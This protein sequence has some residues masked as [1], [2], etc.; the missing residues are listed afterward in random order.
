MTKYQQFTDNIVQ[1][2]HHDDFVIGLAA[3]GSWITNELDDY[4]DIDLVMVTR[5]KIGGDKARMMAY[6]AQFG[7]LLNAFTG[8]HVGEP[9]L[10][11]C[12]YDHPLLHVDIKFV[13]LEEFAH[14][15]ETPVLL[16][17]KAN[18]LQQVLDSTISTYPYPDNQWIEDRFWIWI[19]YTLLKAARGEYFEALDAIGF[20]RNIVIGP[21]LHIRHGNLPRRLRRV[22]MHLPTAAVDDLK[23]TLAQY[24]KASIMD[25]LRQIINMYLTLRSNDMVHQQATEARVM[26]YFDELTPR[27]RKFTRLKSGQYFYI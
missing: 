2:L 16:L 19:H 5:E 7:H 8:E 23:T 27:R 12:L 4:S 26:A 21:L 1:Q 15:V 9:R 13:T 20:L 10:L 11:I 3:G 18:Q 6:A 24:N 22:E 17:D 25:A 14:R